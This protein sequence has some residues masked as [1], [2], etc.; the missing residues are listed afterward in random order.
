MTVCI[1]LKWL[2]IG[3]VAGCVNTEINLRVS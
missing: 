3:Q 2:K 1:G